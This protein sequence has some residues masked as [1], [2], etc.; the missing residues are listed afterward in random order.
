MSGK[1]LR[2]PFAKGLLR[3]AYRGALDIHER[4][5]AF[6]SGGGDEPRLYYG[7]ARG[8]DL[9]GP[10]VKIRK[11]SEAF[12]ER[13]W[14]YNLVYVL[15]N[16]PYLPKA[17]LA[18]LKARSIPIVSNQNGVFYPAWFAGDWEAENKRMAEQYHL[19]DYVFHQSEFCR[20][21][22]EKFLGARAGAGEVLY[23]AVDTTRFTPAEKKRH[24]RD[25]TFYFLLAGK[26]QAH[27]AYRLEASVRGLSVARIQGLNARLI[28][29]GAIDDAAVQNAMAVIGKLGIG[30][31]V[32][33]RGP[34][35]QQQAP[36][37]FAAADAYI[38]TNH[39]DACPSTVI[40][41]MASGLPVL[42]ANSG[43]VPE[44][45]GGKGGV[46]MDTG[47]C[48]DEQLLPSP[49][50]VAEGMARIVGNRRAFAA[51]ARA[52]AVECFDMAHWLERH[53]RVFESLLRGERG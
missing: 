22:A 29:A 44:L 3:S 19:A 46:A 36:A 43:G 32:E 5:S 42:Y 41:A 10:K 39:N 17:S 8:G 34:Y 25:D 50:A 18:R 40:E 33:F 45:V 13:L 27:Q 26:V 14:T 9:G 52:R 51:A 24:S 37:L 28:I 15:S 4:L 1:G 7:G 48:W 2:D 38:M 21:C 6:T 11:L 49:D 30:D 35:S 23:N 31:F 12:P 16:A 47:E 53:R 20:L